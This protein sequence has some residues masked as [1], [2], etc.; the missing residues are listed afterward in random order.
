[1]PREY[2]E[3]LAAA[4]PGVQASGV[5]EG[6]AGHVECQQALT[7]LVWA[8]SARTVGTAARPDGQATASLRGDAVFDTIQKRVP[9]VVAAVMVLAVTGQAALAGTDDGIGPSAVANVNAEQVDGRHAIKYTSNKTAR[10]GRLMAFGA[11]GYLPDNI[12]LKAMDA[13]KIDGIDSTALA[14]IAALQ[15]SAGAVNEADNPVHWNQL[16]GVP[17][18]I[19]TG[20]TRSWIV[21]ATGLIPLNGT[22]VLVV[23]HPVGLDVETTLIPDT[24]TGTFGLLSLTSGADKVS[25]EY[26]QRNGASL[27]QVIVFKNIGPVASGVK[28]R[29][30]VWND[31]YLSPSAAREMV[32]ATFYKKLPKQYRP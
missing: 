3:A 10:K 11:T 12:I 7:G 5:E 28:L 32:K 1:V 14:T 26:F 6:Y 29:A 8:L 13:D 9:W 15:S 25:G 23:E 18:A 30:T 16:Q 22:G 20:T 27:A 19:L 17:P 2:T 4:C 31:A 24:N 21:I